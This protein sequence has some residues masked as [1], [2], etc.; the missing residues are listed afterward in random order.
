MA[1]RRY[2]TGQRVAPRLVRIEVLHA[3]DILDAMSIGQWLTGV[4]AFEQRLNANNPWPNRMVFRAEGI[5]VV[6]DELVGPSITRFE[7][8]IR[9]YVLNQLRQFRQSIQSQRSLGIV[10]RLL[11]KI[12]KGK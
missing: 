2:N 3:D 9:I 11:A 10:G 5:S 6:I 1:T 8:R 4:S 7:K 12:R